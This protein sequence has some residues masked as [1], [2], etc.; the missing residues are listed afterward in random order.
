M[1]ID[2]LPELPP[3]GCNENIFTA[4]DV[5]S[6]Y[7]FAYPFSKPTAVKTTKVLKDIMTGH[8][9]L[10]ALIIT[11]KRSVFVSQFIHEVAEILGLNLKHATTEHEQ[12]I[13]VL[14]RAHATM[15]TFLKMA[16]VEYRK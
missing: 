7:A 6:R 16:T 1:Q 5:F 2:L 8:A 9:Y 14:E 3:S 11:D 15:K 10:P 13:G 4:K 12:T